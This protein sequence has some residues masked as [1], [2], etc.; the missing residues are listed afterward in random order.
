MKKS[1]IWVLLFC[2]GF[3]S[4]SWAGM[5]VLYDQGQGETFEMVCE[6]GLSKFGGDEFYTIMDANRGLIYYVMPK[7]KKYTVMTA[8]EMR[9]QME[10]TI[11]QMEE[12]KK[13]FKALGE[14]FKG[15]GNIM[16]QDS[17]PEKQKKPEITYKFT[18][19]KAKIAGYPARKVLELRD[20]QPVMELWISKDFMRDLEKACDWEKLQKMMEK[21]TP[22]NLP[23][24]TNQAQFSAFIKEKD[25]GGIPL[26]EVSFKEGLIME[27]K[28]V[29]K[30][31]FPASYFSVPKGFKKVET[32]LFGMPQGQQP[33]P[34]G[35]PW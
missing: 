10:S 14:R 21:M 24:Q 8:E 35:K 12:M 22:R 20:G 33:F 27:V 13:K 18:H 2:V 3:V 30:A 11:S 7:E 29:E 31:K 16:G 34:G 19:E 32:G 28:K 25:L 17:A 4:W 23:P 5:L 9:Q 26:K 1:L 15:F 6:D